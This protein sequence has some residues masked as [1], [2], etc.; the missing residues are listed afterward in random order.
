MSTR[1][2]SRSG[3]GQPIRVL[4]VDDKPAPSEAMCDL[5]GD[6]ADMAVVGTASD[7][8]QSIE[9]AGRLEPDVALVDVKMPGGGPRAAEGIAA[10]SPGTRVIAL[11]AYEDLASVLEMLR[12]GAV[13]YLVK[14]TAPS[15]ILEA[16][17][18]AVRRQASLSAEVTSR[19]IVAMFQQIDEGRESEEVFRRGEERFRGLLDS[20][21]DAVVIV[22]GGGRIVLVNEQTEEMFGYE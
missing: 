22:D 19:V 8:E 17:R 5:V 20:A 9:L 21:P 12:N 16:I 6:Q 14:G 15:E 7:A 3:P 4:V 2:A 11:S 13:G 1:A 10:A 18:R